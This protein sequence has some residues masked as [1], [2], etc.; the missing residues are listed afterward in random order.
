MSTEAG[1]RRPDLAKPYEAPTFVSPDDLPPDYMAL[2]SLCFGLVG[3][4]AQ[5]HVCR[6]PGLAILVLKL[7]MPI[8]QSLIRRWESQQDQ[9]LFMGTIIKWRALLCTTAVCVSSVFHF[10]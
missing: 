3:F 5:V 7:R 10:Y 8:G 4:F 2:L 6:N 1:V 9:T